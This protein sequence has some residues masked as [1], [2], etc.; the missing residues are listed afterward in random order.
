MTTDKRSGQ[1]KTMQMKTLEVEVVRVKITLACTECKQRNYN[2]TK[3]KKNHPERMETKKYCKFCH[4]HTLH[5]ETME[6]QKSA[7]KPQKK[8]WF[9]GLQSEFEKIVWTDRP[10]LAKQTVVVVVITFI[11]AVVISVMDSGILECINFLMK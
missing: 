7:D 2:M 1:Q 11:L 8:S 10:T 6:K 4:R 9:Q 3:E 5:K